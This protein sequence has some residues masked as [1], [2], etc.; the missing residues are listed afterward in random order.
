M[1]YLMAQITSNDT[2]FVGV[3][4]A[5]VG[6]M[7]GAIV[8]LYYTYKATVQRELDECKSDRDE[9]RRMVLSVDSRVAS[10]EQRK[11]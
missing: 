11:A 7:A 10:I 3:A 9:L 4:T 1:I 6:P 5:I 2:V 8:H